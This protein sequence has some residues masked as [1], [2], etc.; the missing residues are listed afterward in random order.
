MIG[1]ACETPCTQAW[2][3]LR[4]TVDHA[5]ALPDARAAEAM[6]A[7]AVGDGDRPLVAGETGA[8]AYAGLVA[9]AGDPALRQALGLDAR[10]R[11]LVPNTE[12]AT[13]PET[14]FRLVG[15]TAK[16]VARRGSGACPPGP[17]TGH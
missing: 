1:L 8:A 17:F 10:S 14:Y 9:A 7:L 11:V 5:L 3:L 12:G 4:A 16:D 13:D 2:P 15:R 6:R